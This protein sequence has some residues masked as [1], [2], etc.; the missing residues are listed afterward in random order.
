[1]CYLGVGDVHVRPELAAAVADDRARVDVAELAA[2]W[3]ARDSRM[4]MAP[5]VSRPE[6][7]AQT[8]MQPKLCP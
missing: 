6:M 8:A 3:A 7:A 4:V 5:R 1:V 2:E